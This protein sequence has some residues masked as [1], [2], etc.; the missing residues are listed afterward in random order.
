MHYNI[1]LL[2]KKQLIVPWLIFMESNIQYYAIFALLFPHMAW[3]CL[4]VYIKN[5]LF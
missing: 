4:F 1:A 2:H 3:D 5:V